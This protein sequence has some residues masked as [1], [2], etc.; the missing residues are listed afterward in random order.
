[1][2]PNATFIYRLHRAEAYKTHSI[3]Y[4]ERDRENKKGKERKGNM[5][6]DK[7]IDKPMKP[8]RRRRKKGVGAGDGGNNNNLN[9]KVALCL[10]IL[11]V[12]LF[13]F[14]HL[15]MSFEII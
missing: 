5:P 9:K 8:L 11:I 3:I 13:F 7:E 14:I 2:K 1:M 4:I 6:R 15:L 10:F 12:I